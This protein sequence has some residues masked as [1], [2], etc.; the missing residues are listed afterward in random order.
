MSGLA[1]L[2]LGR[3]SVAFDE[4]ASVSALGLLQRMLTVTAI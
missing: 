2:V 1:Q 4:V 3:G